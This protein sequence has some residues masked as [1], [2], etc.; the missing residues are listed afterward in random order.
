MSSV[1]TTG[2]ARTEGPQRPVGVSHRIGTTAQR[3]LADRPL[4]HFNPGQRSENSG[5][6][7]YRNTHPIVEYMGRS[8]HSVT[9]AVRARTMLGGPYIGMLAS[10]SLAA[11]P[12][13]AYLH[14]VRSHLRT[15]NRGY[16]GYIGNTL[17]LI[18]KAAS[19]SGA[20]GLR[21][22][23]LYN[24]PGDLFVRWWLAVAEQA[25]TRLAA[26]TLGLA[27]AL[28]LRERCRL[29]SAAPV[30]LRELPPQLLVGRHQLG[31]LLLKPRHQCDN[32][33]ALRERHAFGSAHSLS[34][35]QR[36]AFTATPLR[37]MK[38][39]INYGLPVH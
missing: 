16:V 15:P 35:S 39:L 26:R 23:H 27:A 32:L 20:C 28:A 34:L 18:H 29:P 7:P 5:N 31:D 2:L 1:W 30:G 37:A 21:H 8:L 19:T 38:P 6:P 22:R 4:T 3:V 25:H 17:S 13:P 10:H 36:P 33:I 12:A 24:R 11:R 9:Q 14:S